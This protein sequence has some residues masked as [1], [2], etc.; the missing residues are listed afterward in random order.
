MT[1][2]LILE[3][4]QSILFY[5]G[6]KFNYLYILKIKLVWICK[7]KIYFITVRLAY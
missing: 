7:P 6:Y 5:V 1:T 3:R 2:Y 4:Q